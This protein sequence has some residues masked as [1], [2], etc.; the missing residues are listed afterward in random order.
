MAATSATARAIPKAIRYVC[1]CRPAAP[2]GMIDEISANEAT[3]S[4]G[5][6]AN[7]CRRV[8]SSDRRSCPHTW[9]KWAT[10]GTVERHRGHC[11]R[12]TSFSGWQ[13]AI[14]QSRPDSVE[15]RRQRL[16]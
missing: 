4:S 6:A 3:G 11:T 16:A 13:Y 8:W 15:L 1:G 10:W 12:N 14:P 7:E 2:R 9:Q 5:L